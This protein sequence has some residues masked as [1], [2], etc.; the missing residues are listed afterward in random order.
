MYTASS[1][2]SSVNSVRC[3]ENWLFSMLVLEKF[4]RILVVISCIV[5][6]MYFLTDIN[7]AASTKKALPNY[8]MLF[9]FSGT[10]FY[11]LR[12]YAHDLAFPTK[13]LL[14]KDI[15]GKSTQ[16]IEIISVP[17]CAITMSE[18]T[19]PRE[20]SSHGKPSHNVG[21]SHT[22]FHFLCPI[23]L[24]ISLIYQYINACNYKYS[25]ESSFMCLYM[26]RY[27]YMFCVLALPIMCITLSSEIYASDLYN[28]LSHPYT[29]PKNSRVYVFFYL[30]SI[31]NS[32]RSYGE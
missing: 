25:S 22:Q 10:N 6:S 32:S 3:A 7:L 12:T 18:P 17:N 23:V 5:V 9:Y 28:Y 13:G 2:T 1:L 30:L 15:R 19:S 27:V 26:N 24:V 8:S 16:Y 31:C 29:R 20:E 4:A 14:P 21:R 11:G